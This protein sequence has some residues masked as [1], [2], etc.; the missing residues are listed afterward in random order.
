LEDRPSWQQWA[1]TLGTVPIGLI[2]FAA[3]VGLGGARQSSPEAVALSAIAVIY[4]PPL[5]VALLAPSRRVGVFG[6][7]TAGWAAVMLSIV[8]VYF[9]GERE[10][11]VA[12]GIGML[13]RSA[14]WE[15]MAQAVSTRLADADASA[16]EVVTSL[17]LTAPPA[18]DDR[19]SEKHAP[20]PWRAPD[21]RGLLVRARLGSHTSDAWMRRD[22]S[23]EFT[24]LHPDLL[25]ALAPADPSSQVEVATPVD[26]GSA[27]VPLLVLDS[28]GLGPLSLDRV[29]VVPCADCAPETGILGRNVLDAF[30]WEDQPEQQATL[31]TALQAPNRAT[32]ARPFVAVAGRFVRFPGGLVQVKLGVENRST[33]LLRDAVIAVECGPHA[34]TIDL[35]AVGPGERV[36]ARR[37]LPEHSRCAAYRAELERARW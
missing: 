12:T 37:R 21:D 2:A 32:D 10:D 1:L 5:T 33:A 27:L 31:A 34:W 24:A 36:F 3:F 6:I 23:R 35:G 4:L 17:R 8:P 18:D 26:G 16:E 15:D 28:L 29:G 11:A 13:L 20:L 25:R 9:P 22:P 30:H 19:P 14:D 7:S